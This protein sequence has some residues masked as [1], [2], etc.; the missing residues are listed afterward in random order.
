[1]EKRDLTKKFVDEIYSKPPRK[2][3]P[4]NKIVYNSIDEIWFIDLADF[5]D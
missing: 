2:N 1:M 3:Y 4:T 5:S